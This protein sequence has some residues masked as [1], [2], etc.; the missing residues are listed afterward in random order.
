M[1][2]R[3]QLR[4]RL[5]VK[6]ARPRD[7]RH[8]VRRGARLMC[9]SRPLPEAVTRSTGTGARASGSAARSASMRALHG[10]A[11]SAGLVGPEVRAGRGA[12]V[13]GEGRG[14][15]GPAPEVLR[16]AERLADQRRADRLAVPHDQ[17]AVGLVREDDL[18]D[19][20]HRRSG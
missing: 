20:G 18:G 5:R 9:G 4:H 11:T 7:A 12:G 19:A 1:C 15:R 2:S 13:V 6:P 8:L 16:V 3:D 17:A 10:V 14:G